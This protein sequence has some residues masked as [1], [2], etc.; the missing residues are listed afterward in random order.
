[1]RIAKSN[2]PVSV[3]TKQAELAKSSFIV[4]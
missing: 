3:A 4:V 2:L 1:M